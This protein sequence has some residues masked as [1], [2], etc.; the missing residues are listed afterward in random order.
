MKRDPKWQEAGRDSFPQEE[1]GVPEEAGI[2]SVCSP[3][4]ASCFMP[5]FPFCPFAF[6]VVVEEV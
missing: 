1:Q 4:C 6:S 3:M 5:Q 2:R